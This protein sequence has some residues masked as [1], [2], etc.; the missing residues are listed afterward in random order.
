[1]KQLNLQFDKAYLFLS[2]PD[3]IYEKADEALLSAIKEDRRVEHKPAQTQPLQLG[4]YFSMWANTLPDG[5]LVVL[6]MEND[7]S[8]SGCLLLENTGL[9]KREKVGQT[10]CPD[11]HYESK[12]ISVTNPK[13]DRDFI[14]L[15]RVFYREDK[16]VRDA[17]GH[18]FHRVADE[19][20]RLTEEE[21]RELEI[22]KRQ[23]DLEQEPVPL[24]YPDDFD[25][26][27]ISEF[28]KQVIA[29]RNLSGY[30]PN[31]EIL[32]QR[33]LG[34]FND[35]K[36]VPNTAC[37]LLC[38]KDP[39]AVIPGCKVRF[40]RFEGEIEKTGKEYN[41]IKD[42]EIEASVPLLIARIA[43]ILRG[44]L[45]EFS[46]FDAGG[47]FHTVAE[48]PGAVVNRCVKGTRRR[49]LLPFRY[50][51]SLHEQLSPQGMVHLVF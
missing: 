47:K 42:L 44:Q 15:F 8:F 26:A 34:K 33:R 7:G 6:G 39:G 45:R 21:I 17:S 22:D 28:V 36:F 50:R 18:A 23:V 46:H 20:R 12:R 4:E 14:V 5:G 49:P 10:H 27:L 13:G 40:L 24:T 32:V 48:Y 9:N 29:T 51:T 31:E 19:K 1:M 43:D 30:H 37:A 35:G 41:A 16:V 3:E 25:E 11:A 2:S 38:A